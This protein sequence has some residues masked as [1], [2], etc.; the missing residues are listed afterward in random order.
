[1]PFRQ[2]EL[3]FDLHCLITAG[4]LSWVLWAVAELTSET[5]FTDSSWLWLIYETITL[6]FY[7]P[8][9]KNI[10]LIIRPLTLLWHLLN[11]TLESWLLQVPSLLF[12]KWMEVRKVCHL[13]CPSSLPH[14]NGSNNPMC[15][16]CLH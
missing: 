16:F 1:M 13:N 5:D 4:R 2:F 11:V 12:R 7:W 3:C 14:E 8:H 10:I 6:K 15:T 9:F